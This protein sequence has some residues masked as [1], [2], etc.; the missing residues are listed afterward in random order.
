MIRQASHPSALQQRLVLLSLKRALAHAFPLANDEPLPERI[1]QAI[2]TLKQMDQ[3]TEKLAP[4]EVPILPSA[5]CAHD[6][7]RL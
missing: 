7:E 4:L 5:L 3:A 1:V 2:F 6:N